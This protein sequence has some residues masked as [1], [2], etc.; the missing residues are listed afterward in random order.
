[1]E[2]LEKEIYKIEKMII[3]QGLKVKHIKDFIKENKFSNVLD[4]Q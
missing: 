4:N 1:M 2:E 3:K